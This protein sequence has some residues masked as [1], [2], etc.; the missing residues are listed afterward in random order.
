MAARGTRAGKFPK[1]GLVLRPIERIITSEDIAT[2]QLFAMS[3]GGKFTKGPE[4]RPNQLFGGASAG[5]RIAGSLGGG[6][7]NPAVVDS[8]FTAPVVAGPPSS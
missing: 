6:V 8:S 4:A 1:K 3:T 2:A 7:Y 5:T